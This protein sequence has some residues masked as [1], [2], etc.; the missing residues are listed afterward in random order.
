MKSTFLISALPFNHFAH[1]SHLLSQSL[2][3]LSLL[4]FVFMTS[5]S[6]QLEAQ[7]TLKPSMEITHN[8][9][10]S[11]CQNFVIGAYVQYVRLKVRGADGGNTEIVGGGCN[12]TKKGGSGATME[13]VFTV[14]GNTNTLSPGGEIRIVAGEHGRGES[15]GNCTKYAY[16]SGGGSS[17]AIYKAPGA[18]EWEALVVAG[19]GGG[20]NCDGLKPQQRSN[21][22]EGGADSSS[23]GNGNGG[24]EKRYAGADASGGG[25]GYVSNGGGGAQSPFSTNYSAPRCRA[26]GS[27][28]GGGTTP[29]EGG[30]G[31]SGGGYARS[32]G[33]G[34]GGYT[35]GD[36][37]NLRSNG[38][39]G[40]SFIT[41]DYIKWVMKDQG[42][43]TGGGAE[44]DGSVTIEGWLLTWT[45]GHNDDWNNPL[46]WTPQVLP[47]SQT[48]VVI[49]RTF[50]DPVIKNTYGPRICRYMII[51]AHA[52]LTI[53]AGGKLGIPESGDFGI[54]CY[55]D[56]VNNGTLSIG[57]DS[58]RVK[59]N[60]IHLNTTGTLTN[61]GLIEVDSTKFGGIYVDGPSAVFTN[62]AS[63]SLK[64]GH[65]AHVTFDALLADGSGTIINYGSI[66]IKNGET[67]AL[68]IL[69]GGLLENKAGASIHIEH[70]TAI[71]TTNSAFGVSSDAFVKNWGNITVDDCYRAMGIFAGSYFHNYSTG[72]IGLGT[73]TEVI[74]G[75]KLWYTSRNNT[76]L[77]NDGM[78]EALKVNPDNGQ[79]GV[80]FISGTFTNNGIMRIVEDFKIFSGMKAATN[81]TCGYLEVTEKITIG[82]P[83]VNNGVL[84]TNR[85]GSHD[86]EGT[87]NGVISN[88]KNTNLGD[89]QNNNNGHIFKPKTGTCEI[90]NFAAIGTSPIHDIDVF[91]YTDSAQTQHA[92]A[93]VSNQNS[94]FPL[95]S[96]PYPNRYGELYA[97]ATST[98]N[99]CSHIFPVKVKIEDTTPPRFDF[100][101]SSHTRYTL[102]GACG[103]T[104]SYQVTATDICSPPTLTQT[105]GLDRYAEFPVGTTFNSYVAEDRFG[106]TSVCSFSV[107]VVDTTPPVL[108][109]PQNIVQSNDGG[110]CDAIIHYTFPSGSGSCPGES[111][112]QNTGHISGAAFPK[113]VTTNEFTVTDASGNT[114]TCSFTV[115]INDD[116][117][118]VAN[119][120]SDMVVS[121]DQGQCDAL[122]TYSVPTTDNC[123]G[124]SLNRDGGQASGT[125]FPKGVTTNS[126]TVTDA[127]GNTS[128]CSFTVTV[129]DTEAPVVNCPANITTSNDL[130]LC[131]AIVNYTVTTG[132]NCPGE[133]LSQTE[134]QTAGSSFPVGIT[135]NSFTV[136]DASGNTGTCSFTVTVNDTQNPVV[137]CPANITTSNDQDLCEALVNYT[138]TTEDNCPGESLSQTA[139]QTA[140]SSF[141]VGVT[142]NSFMVTDASGNTA[143][144]SFTVTVVDDQNPQITC[145][146][147][148]TVSNDAN[149]CDAVVTYA[150]PVGTDNCP[151]SITSQTAGLGSGVAFPRGTTTET[152]QVVDGHGNTHACSFTITINDVDQPVFSCP[153]S[154]VVRT[155]DL[156][157][158][159][160]L[161]V[162]QDLDPIVSD[163]CSIQSLT[164]DY[165]QSSS[166]DGAVFA[167]GKTLVTWT[168]TDPSG[169]STVCAYNI[170][171]NDKEAPIF[172]NCPSDTTITIPF[173]AGGGYHTWAALTATDNCNSPGQLTITGFPLSGSFF[174]VGMTPVNWTATDK[175]NNTRHCDFNV[176]VVE[177]GAPAP[178]GWTN[179]G[180]GSSNNCATNYD[181]TTG[182]LSIITSGG[183]IHGTSDDFCGITIPNS[184]QIIDFRARVIPPG[185][186]Y[187]DQAGIMMRQSLSGNAACASMYLTGTSIPIMGLRPSAGSMP[188]GMPGTAVSTPYWV[189]LY[190]YGATIQGY[191]SGDGVNWTLVQSYPNVLSS[192]LYLTLFAKTSGSQGTATIDSISI[193]GTAARMGLMAEETA[194]SLEAYPNPFSEDLFIKVANALPG[195][196]YDVRL[197]NM[198]GQRVYGYKTGA[199]AAGTIDQRISLEHLAAGTYLLEVS[200]G[201][202]RKALKVVKQ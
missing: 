177:Q 78:I 7:T 196:T 45:G 51:E 21:D 133:S 52:T 13:V 106:N 181:A 171:I 194:L 68:L 27:Q 84:V 94:L 86:I 44:L 8:Y 118:P 170:K 162:G 11:A 195:E 148:I 180:A 23:P 116:E 152:Y 71:T 201:V 59:N 172:D 191:I 46:N 38:Y 121:T 6:F 87:N 90:A 149:S 144:C 166:L 30:K 120:P 10:D 81:D 16:G 139:G 188:L 122:V 164:N 64:A 17:G 159:D 69:N 66:D 200:A 62:N 82:R 189:R 167:K 41:S 143:S 32:G 115:T 91:L 198:M 31:F 93:Y 134:G 57:S 74:F 88:L 20:S 175:R 113:G 19:A 150:V 47:T 132:D 33:G 92:A 108:T 147:N 58:T 126:F 99:N 137:N 184:D 75:L 5:I 158:C 12:V 124:E 141:P 9:G 199:S 48:P 49:A 111:L 97:S 157:M 29:R 156:G 28:A 183:N 131:E 185:T 56:I 179:G 146:A 145:P 96:F 190:R 135:S 136:T 127:S 102:P 165:N 54:M 40:T 85:N 26:D 192:P 169:N 128:T 193:N 42:G 114:G 18:T 105:S 55:G 3:R 35:G 22:G 77:I 79:A 34:G 76:I 67:S 176:T 15:R 103:A 107:T 173:A 89:I 50:R 155:T 39:G 60:G 123:P 101:P 72:Y 2:V 202:Q 197:S 36:G 174:S 43:S 119:C 83:F 142:T 130:D 61:N 53:N 163:N 65:K 138:V 125:A 112:N 95:D 129:N 151:G 80:E 70:F 182:T 100:C 140:G 98:S 117:A 186:G 25:G 154:N 109:C 37:G 161:A 63:G 14:D 178:S 160:H 73:N 4:L 104:V 1:K 187:Y 110:Y 24:A 168:A 153:T